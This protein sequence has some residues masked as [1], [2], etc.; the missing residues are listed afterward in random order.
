MIESALGTLALVALLG[1][2][3][4]L[5]QATWYVDNI[6]QGTSRHTLTVK[7]TPGNH[8]VCVWREGMAKARC[9]TVTA[10]AGRTTIV[11][12]GVD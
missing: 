6:G 11:G 8:V 2:E 12:I 7:T 9:K 5:A 10:G 3:P 1:G 4:S